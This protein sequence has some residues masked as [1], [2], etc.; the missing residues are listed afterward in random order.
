MKPTDVHLG[1]YIDYGVEHKDSKVQFVDHVRISKYK[2]I[3]C[4]G[5]HTKLVRQNFF[6]EKCYKCCIVDIVINDHVITY[7][8]G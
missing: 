2:N 7:L 6:D 1:T 4:E 8:N 3:F 5:P